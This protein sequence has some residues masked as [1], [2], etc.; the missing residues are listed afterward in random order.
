MRPEQLERHQSKQTTIK[1]TK[2]IKQ[3]SERSKDNRNN[4]KTIEKLTK[5]PNQSN[6]YQKAIRKQ[7]ESNQRNPK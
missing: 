4:H 7:S 1:A 5:Q 3:Q 2:G 6:N